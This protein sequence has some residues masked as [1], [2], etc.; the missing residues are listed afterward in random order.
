MNIIAKSA[1]VTT[2]YDLYA[3]TQAPD[4]EKLTTVKGAVLTLTSWVLY[5]DVN[6][7]GDEVT[8][9][10]M[11]T[12]DG[13]AYCTNSATFCKDFGNAVDM[14]KQFGEEFTKIQ[15]ITGTSKN[16]REYIGCKVVK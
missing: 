10:A 16:G 6:S 13:K 5:T 7:K 15:V 1:S 2:A 11:T 9:M 12:D 3:L 8:L 14:Y 4:R